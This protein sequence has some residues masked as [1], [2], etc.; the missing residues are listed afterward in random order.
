MSWFRKSLALSALVAL[1]LAS[2]GAKK[3][4]NAKPTTTKM[5]RKKGDK[6]SKTDP[7]ANAGPAKLSVPVPPGHDAKGLVIPYRD[8]NGVMQMRFTMDLGSRINEEQMAMKKLI[9]ETFDAT[10][11]GEMTIDLPQS[12]LNLSTRVIST[13]SGVMIKRSDFELSGQ[14]MEFNTE[15]RAGRV[16]GKVRMLIYN[17]ENETNS[18]EEAKPIEK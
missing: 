16:A 6:K 18:P 3:E 7:A 12:M 10:G 9:I 5:D 17:L 11:N 4:E 2:A 8:Q 1:A 13:E 14:K 15:T